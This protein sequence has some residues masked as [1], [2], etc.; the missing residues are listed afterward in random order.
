MVSAK[1]CAFAAVA[2][3]VALAAAEASAETVRVSDCERNPSMDVW[4]AADVE[5]AGEVMKDVFEKAGVEAEDVPFG[6][7]NLFDRRNTDVI[8]CAFRTPELCRGYAFP[9]QPLARMHFALYA[10]PARA[11]EMLSARITE[12]PRMKVGYSPVSQGRCDDRERYFRQAKLAPEY[13]EFETSEAAVAALRKG[14]VDLL[15]LYTSDGR[16][17]EGLVEV[18]PIGSRNVYF[19]VRKDRLDLLER[20]QKAYRECYIAN[21]GRYD[22][23]R[24]SILGVKKPK[25]RV[26]VAAYMR[27]NL[28][29]VTPDGERS[30][31]IEDWLNAIAS[32][33]QWDMDYVYGPYEES[34]KDVMAGRLD[35]FCGLGFSADRSEKLLY[36]HTPIGMLRVYLWTKRGNRFKAGD[37]TTWNGMRVGLLAGSFSADRVKRDLEADG[38]SAGV[39]CVEYA[40]DSEMIKAYFDGEIDACVDVEMPAL[41]NERALHLYVS[42]PMY[43]CVAPSRRD[44]FLELEK[45]FD[46]V[47]DDFPKYMRMLTEHHYGIRN[48]M[49]V[50]TFREAEWLKERLKDPS[51]VMIDFSPWP[52]HLKDA[53]GNLVHF[54]KEFLAELSKRTGLRFDTHP[55]TGIQTAEAKFLRGDTKFWIPYPSDVDV[56]AMGGVSV[57]SLPV[58]RTYAYMLGSD[59]NNDE[60]VLWAA[61]DAPAELVGIIRKAVSGIEPV[62]MQE[63]FVKAAAERNVARRVFGMTDE[64]FERMLVVVGFAALSLVVVFALVMIVLLKRQVRIA[65]EAA[66]VAEEYSRAKTRFLAMMSHELRTPLN[67]VIGFAEFLTPADCD[68]ERRQKY[69]KGIRLSANALLDLINDIL[70]LSKLDSGAMHMRSGECDVQ[71]IL[72]E[73]TA[74]FGYKF[75]KRGVKLAVRR[76]SSAPPPIL[77]LS[78]QGLK[79]ALINLVGNSAKFTES[80][81]VEVTYGWEPAT[82]TLSLSVRDTGC[83]ISGEKM[84]HLFD[85]FV[86]DISSRMKHAEGEMRGTGLG[87]PI[88]KRI[89]DNAG[90]TVEVSSEVGRGTTFAL[91]IPSLEVVRP[92]PQGAPEPAGEIPGRILVVDDMLMNREILEIHLRNIGVKD[93]RLAENGVAALA[94]MKDWTPDAVLTDVWMPEMDGHQLAV[95]MKADARLATIP[96]MAITADVDVGSTFDMS[97]FAKVIAKP[98]TGT[99]LRGLFRREGGGR[100]NLV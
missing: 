96:V 8:K 42:H 37:Q 33:A 13:V 28:F 60:L 16:R 85:P 67:A 12:W 54:A 1:R 100:N 41:D 30:G 63:M 58:P 55:Q 88:V 66:A 46:G 56:A 9:L 27:G 11:K 77:K 39:V 2:A 93:V 82:R 51:P 80:G 22:D 76:T 52:V 18:V 84:A 45:A 20:L 94:A 31:V 47:C 90:G 91:R 29:D 68:E 59:G 92:A 36:S 43:V 72:D 71:K 26:R 7:D 32:H 6:G 61:R 4:A 34:L 87:L 69:V 70:D 35:V 64:E 14:K 86:Q 17:P 38:N 99:K 21:I 15:F 19:A 75:S 73:M 24:A 62:D 79:Q 65:R 48:E 40:T 49:S 5:F 78:H 53:G 23:L 81:E 95:A 44:V 97:V 50:L 57:F 74:I 83:G 3:A 25:R 89:V 10:T 98:V